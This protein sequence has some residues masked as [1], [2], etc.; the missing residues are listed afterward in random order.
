MFLISLVEVICPFLFHHKCMV[1]VLVRCA[2]S[3]IFSIGPDLNSWALVQCFLNQYIITIPYIY[4]FVY[5]GLGYKY[6][7]GSR[8]VWKSQ[9]WCLQALKEK[10]PIKT[11]C[12]HILSYSQDTRK[13]GGYLYASPLRLIAI[14]VCLFPHIL[15][16]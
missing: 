3:A 14:V 11:L 4:C 5:E 1:V 13:E 10:V 6:L 7:V 8:F 16:Y 12:Y 9:D 2:G 15:K